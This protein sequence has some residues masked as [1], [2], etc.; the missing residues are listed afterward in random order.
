MALSPPFEKT[1]NFKS[2]NIVD[3]SPF[4]YFVDGMNIPMKVINECKRT[5][6]K[7]VADC[8]HSEYVLLAYLK[9][10]KDVKS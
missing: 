3:M 8:E 2:M 5:H 4:G 10:C 6:G 1:V 7:Y 9:A